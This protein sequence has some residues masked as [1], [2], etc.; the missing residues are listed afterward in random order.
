MRKPTTTEI[1]VR[2]AI[3]CQVLQAQ[4]LL[5]E[6][7]LRIV[8]KAPDA[9]ADERDETTQMVP[10]FRSHHSRVERVITRTM[11]RPPMVGVPHS[12]PGG[13]AA[14]LPR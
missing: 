14:A 1:A 8:Q 11:R 13:G 3:F 5:L 9:E 2:A 7:L 12:L 10:A 4:V 6:E